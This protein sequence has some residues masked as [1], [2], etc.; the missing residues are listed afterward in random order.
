MQNAMKQ[1]ML[2]YFHSIQGYSQLTWKT[3]LLYVTK[4]GFSLT[5]MWTMCLIVPNHW[6]ATMT[7]QGTYD[8]LSFPLETILDLAYMACI[9]IENGIF[10]GFQLVRY[11]V[12]VL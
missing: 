12:V 4:S 2:R 5:Q 3:K 1:I 10:I 7:L 9:Q 6:G 11:P 8:Q